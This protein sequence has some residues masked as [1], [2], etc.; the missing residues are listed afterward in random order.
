MAF[1]KFHN[2]NTDFLELQFDLVIEWRSLPRYV[3]QRLVL[4]RRF[5][6]EESLELVLKQPPLV[7]GQAL[8]ALHPVLHLFRSVFRLRPRRRSLFV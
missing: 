3:T 5:V 1:P 8:F 4:L 6:L 7:L 2:S